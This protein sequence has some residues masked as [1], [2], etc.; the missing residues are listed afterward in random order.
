MGIA[1]F[2]GETHFPKGQDDSRINDAFL[3]III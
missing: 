1:Y 2:Q 3:K